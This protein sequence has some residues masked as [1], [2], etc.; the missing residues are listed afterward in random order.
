MASDEIVRMCSTAY[1]TSIAKADRCEAVRELCHSDDPFF[2]PIPIHYCYLH[3]LNWLTVPIII[4]LLIFFFDMLGYICD[5]YVSQAV[6]KLSKYMRITEATAG[7]TIIPLANGMTDLIT[8]MIASYKEAVVGHESATEENI[9]LGAIFGGNLFAMTIIVAAVVLKASN[10]EINDVYSKFIL[11]SKR[12]CRKR[13]E[14]SSHRTD[15]LHGARTPQCALHLRRLRL[16]RDLHL[17]SL[18]LSLF[19]HELTFPTE[20]RR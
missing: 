9:A 13:F 2:N 3:E 18:Q 5:S 4:I 16:G 12:K 6:A 20:Q 19:S 14:N 15:N 7:R 17:A 11:A 10:R 1:L 8:I